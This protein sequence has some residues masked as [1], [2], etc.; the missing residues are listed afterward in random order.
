MI[1]IILTIILI[2][3]II[4]ITVI[5]IIIIK[6]IICL[7]QCHTQIYGI[8]FGMTSQFVYKHSNELNNSAT[9]PRFFSWLYS[10]LTP[11]SIRN[12]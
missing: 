6:I 8:V 7:K 3:I 12:L 9:Q 11:R 2:L 4:N 10:F 1:A 5:I